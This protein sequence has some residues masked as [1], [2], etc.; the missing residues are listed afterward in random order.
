VVDFT[1][2]IAAPDAKVRIQHVPSSTMVYNS[3][4]SHSGEFT[5]QGWG[6]YRI[7]GEYNSS[8]FSETFEIEPTDNRK[9]WRQ[10]LQFRYDYAIIVPTDDEQEV[11]YFRERYKWGIDRATTDA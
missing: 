9:V 11:V 3:D 6:T 4:T 1:V 10:P 7:S 5:S 8:Y 2:D